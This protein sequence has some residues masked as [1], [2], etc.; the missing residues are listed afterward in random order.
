MRS[1]K[2]KEQADF[3]PGIT[4]TAIRSYIQ[5]FSKEQLEEIEM[6]VNS[7]LLERDPSFLSQMDTLEDDG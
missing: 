3:I 1:R 2:L 5:L 7:E 4:L 6:L